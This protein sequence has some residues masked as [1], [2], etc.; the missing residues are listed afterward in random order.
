MRRFRTEGL[1]TF[2]RDAEF[3]QPELA[4]SPKSRRSYFIV[5]FLVYQDET[6]DLKTFSF[7]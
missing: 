7:V 2:K 6:G 5:R 1:R 3:A 4:G